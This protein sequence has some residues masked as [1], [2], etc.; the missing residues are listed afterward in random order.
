MKKITGVFVLLF[1]LAAA[2]VYGETKI[3]FNTKD[4]KGKQVTDSIFAENELT[5]INVW[6][7][8][9]APCI[10][11]MP[12]LAKLNKANKSKGVRV[13]GIPIDVVGRGGS[14]Q[15]REKRNADA[16]IDATKADYT[17]LVPSKEML[18]G[19]LYGIQAVPATIFV[20]S[21]G[22]Q[23]GDIYFGARSQKDWQK[24]IDSILADKK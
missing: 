18:S 1:A 20:D 4:L 9:C 3:E 8:F 10:K 21:S 24:I 6:G 5:M 13:I 23:I 2:T 12:D 16:I 7:T 19:F 15:S 14:I 17:H 22:N 11:E